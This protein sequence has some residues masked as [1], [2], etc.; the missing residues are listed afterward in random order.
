MSNTK[1]SRYHK[2]CAGCKRSADDNE[3]SRVNTAG[4]VD[5]VQTT[6]PSA[7]YRSLANP[8]PLGLAGF[9]FTTFVLGLINLQTQSVKVPNI[10]V[11]PA[12]AYGGV[13]QF[14]AGMWEMAIGNTFGA[15]ALASYGAFW[16][17]YA[18]IL[19]PGSGVS[20]AY[21]ETADFNHAMG[22]F[23]MGF[24][25]FSVF[26]TLCTMRTTAFLCLLF[27][28]VDVTFLLLS[29]SNFLTGPDGS[30][31]QELSRVGGA[32]A[33]LAS[34][35]AWYIMYAGMA[36]NKNRFEIRLEIASKFF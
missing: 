21:P 33:M 7:P 23:M 35:T 31:H 11:G 6:G 22:F 28:L 30:P 18:I 29:L 3:I 32:F 13:T 1:P 14:C 26:L 9:A 27:C 20:A 4:T 24:F 34:F 10:V 15:T 36:N 19:I 17:S 8:A 5:T 16:V 2:E 25:I 12:I